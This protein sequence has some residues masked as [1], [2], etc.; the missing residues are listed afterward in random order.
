MGTNLSLSVFCA[1]RSSPSNCLLLFCY[2]ILNTL[3]KFFLFVYLTFGWYKWHQQPLPYKN[4][5]V[6]ST[7]FKCEPH[8]ST[9]KCCA[10]KYPDPDTEYSLLHEFAIR[11]TNFSTAQ[12]AL[13][14]SFKQLG[15]WRVCESLWNLPYNF[16]YMTNF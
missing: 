1:A 10:V 16:L 3:F 12:S 14:M 6:V 8:T 9:P 11:N 13:S 15:V 5:M 2:L 4:L 7:S